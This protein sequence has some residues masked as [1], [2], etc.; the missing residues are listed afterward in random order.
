MRVII[1]GLGDV[2]TQLAEDLTVTKGFELV[3]ID[4]DEEK[5]EDLSGEFDALVLHGDGTEPEL[6]ESAGARGTDALIATTDSDA[7][8]M[9]IAVLGK[10]FSIPRVVAKLQKTSLRTTARELGV[11]HVIS[12]KISAATEISSL[13]HGYD[14]L[15]FS[16]LVQ[17]G[18]RLVEISPGELSG[19]TLS[20]IELPEGTLIASIL[21]EGV[22]HIPRGD[23]ELQENDILIIITEEESKEE[24]IKEKFGQLKTSRRP[25]Q[26][27]EN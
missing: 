3:L 6:L 16:L 19:N 13:L 27:N 22:A 18:A 12:P 2:G 4:Q 25:D 1:A 23:T 8:N 21:R 20:E 17:G 11:D 24:E 15:D 14:V 26:I 7:L 10:K 5:C 9:V